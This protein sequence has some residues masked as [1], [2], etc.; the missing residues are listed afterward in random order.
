MLPAERKRLRS[1]L[2]VEIALQKKGYLRIAGVDEAGRGPLAG[3]VVAAACILPS[4][5]YPEHLNDS[6]Q[7]TPKQR[8]TLFAFLVP[9]VEHAIA[10][11]EVEEIDRLNILQATFQAMKRAIAQLN[12]D[13]LLIDGNQM[14]PTPFPGEALVKGDARS[15]SIAAASVLAK[16]TRDRLMMEQAQQYPQYGFE[17]HKGYGTAEHLK[18]LAKHGPCPLHRRSFEPLKSSF[19]IFSGDKK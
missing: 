10:V 12:P 13:Y 8:E 9:R 2:K 3:P 17:Q 5:F 4:R 1:L 18:A 15:L 6:K 19:L 11:V 7:L 14:P 16:V